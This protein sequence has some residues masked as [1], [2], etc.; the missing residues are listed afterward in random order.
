MNHYFLIPLILFISL[1]NADTNEE[2]FQMLSAI[3]S[4][5]SERVINKLPKAKAGNPKAQL[6]VAQSYLA[7]IPGTHASKT[8]SLREQAW[9]W[10]EKAMTQDT[11]KKVA[12]TAEKEA[13]YSY[14]LEEREDKLRAMV[15]GRY[16]EGFYQLGLLLLKKDHNSKE[17]IAKLEAVAKQGH[18]KAAEKL[19]DQYSN[20]FTDHYDVKKSYQWHKEAAKKGDPSYIYK[21]ARMYHYGFKDKWPEFETDIKKA[22]HY[23]GEA[24]NYGNT[25]AQIYLTPEFIRSKSYPTAHVLADELIKKKRAEGYFYKAEMLFRGQGIDINKEKAIELMK[26]AKK[27]GY[28]LADS[29]LET[30]QEQQ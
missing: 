20:Y 8:T 26:I 21:L 28:F 30:M 2:L 14:Y 12:R 16:P 3:K 24:A 15:K 18:V 13:A 6:K 11:D 4:E 25:E 7:I 17:G 27:K 5:A 22:T 29:A 19:A 23:Y 1:A 10:Y 9:Y